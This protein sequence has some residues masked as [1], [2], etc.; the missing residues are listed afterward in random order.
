MKY[1]LWVNAERTVMI[2]MWDSGTVTV[3]TRESSSH[4]CGPPITVT[5][6]ATS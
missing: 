5:E 6:E 3:A 2:E 1:R 4:T